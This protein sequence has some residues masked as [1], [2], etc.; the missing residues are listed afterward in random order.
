VGMSREQIEE[1]LFAMHKPKIEVTISG[2]DEESR[3]SKPR[4]P[5]AGSAR[6]GGA[7]RVK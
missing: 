4:L 6:Q 3:L 1:L 2:D 7:E 5:V